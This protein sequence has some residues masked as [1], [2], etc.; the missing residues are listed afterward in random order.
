MKKG[1][2]LVF[3]MLMLILVTQHSRAATHFS[4]FH[5]EGPAYM[6]LKSSVE[7]PDLPDE[8]VAQL[9]YTY[10]PVLWFYKSSLWEEPFMLIEAD[11]FLDVSTED[12]AGNLKLQQ[13]G[14][15]GAQTLQSQYQGIKNPV[16]VRLAVDEHQG[17]NYLVIQYWFCYL[18]NYGGAFPLLD[19]DHEGE[20]EM[21]EVILNYDE[22]VLSGHAYPEPYIIAYSRHASGEAHHWGNDVIETEDGHPVSYIAYGTHAAYF[23]DLGWNEYLSKGIKV[24]YDDMNFVLIDEKEWL[25]FPGKWGGQEN[26]PFGPIFQSTKWETPAAW[27][28]QYLDTYQFHL[29]RPGHVLLTNEKGE[30]IGFI[31]GEF[32]N[33]IKNAYAV[34]TDEHEYYNLPKDVYSV[35]INSFDTYSSFDVM[36]NEDGELTHISY[37]NEFVNTVA[38]AYYELSGNVKDHVLRLDKDGDGNIDL[39]LD[40][41]VMRKYRDESPFLLYGV[42]AGVIVLAFLGYRI[43]KKLIK[44][45]IRIRPQLKKDRISIT[46]YILVGAAALFFV[47]WLLSAV[48]DL[49]GDY[50]YEVAFL[51][52][53]VAMY[54]ISGAVPALNKEYSTGKK[55]QEVLIGAGWSLISVW[56][57]FTVLR[58]SNLVGPMDIGI[59]LGYVLA[60]GIAGLLV[61][62]TMRFVQYI[63]EHWTVQSVFFTAGS[64]LVFFWVLTR[65]SP[66]SF[67]YAGYALAV[68]IVLIGI[69]VLRRVRRRSTAEKKT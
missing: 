24:T 5:T 68:G 25:H 60:A 3:S 34:I 64:L 35:E 28:M 66:L 55:I 22:S 62:Y 9:A 31:N 11:Y 32:V 33:E 4:D 61:G 69:G 36:A 26:S 58:Y 10:A 1:I 49:L 57:V 30:R 27:A 8:V 59:A 47:L 48:T 51:Q 40:P 50:G 53:S 43:Q 13:D 14:Y 56:I 45:V 15:S 6:E 12:S 41:S 38:K 18:Y 16:Y 19:L 29:E 37:E 7:I 67:Q 2:L 21:I 52:C 42:I 65:V 17:N 44:K 54:V 63:R 39:T 23:K 46:R 20:W